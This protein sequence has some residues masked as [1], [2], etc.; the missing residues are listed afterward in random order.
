MKLWK[1]LC[2][3]VIAVCYLPLA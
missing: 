3:F 1:V 2:S